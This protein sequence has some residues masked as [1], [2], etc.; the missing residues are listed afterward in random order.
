MPAPPSFKECRC[1]AVGQAVSPA[2]WALDTPASLKRLFSALP[3]RADFV[4]GGELG[5]P[6]AIAHVGPVVF[7]EPRGL[8]D[9]SPVHIQDET[10]FVLVHF[11]SAPRHRE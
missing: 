9:G 3:I 4:V 10:F 2:Y 5:A 8:F 7:I 6:C 1:L 11:Q